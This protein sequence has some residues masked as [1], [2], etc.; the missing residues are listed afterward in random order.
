V[1]PG[2]WRRSAAGLAAKGIHHDQAILAG[3]FHRLMTYWTPTVPGA[4]LLVHLFRAD[5]A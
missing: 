5:L 3:L 1:P 4:F 2:S